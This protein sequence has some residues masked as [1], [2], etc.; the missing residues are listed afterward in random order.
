MVD[1]VT[2]TG[3]TGALQGATAGAST[4]F[5]FGGPVGAG[6]G[7]I[8]GGVIGGIGGIFGGKK[9][10][11][12]KKYM[13]K[14]SAIQSERE[15]NMTAD[16]FRQMLRTARTARAGSMA[17]SIASDITTSSLSTSALSSIG[18]QAQY[19]V[20]FLAEDRRLYSLYKTYMEK[21]GQKANDYTNTMNLISMGAAAVPALTDAYLNNPYKAPASTTQLQQTNS[22]GGFWSNLFNFSDGNDINRAGVAALNSD[23]KQRVTIGDL[24]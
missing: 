18:S 5:M 23:L 15:Q 14:A 4:G 12:A 8:V 20:Q 10:K 19:N 24:V 22:N 16:Q 3:T 6:I 13:K 1:I 2:Y 11:K 9:A 17:A 7:S 21:A